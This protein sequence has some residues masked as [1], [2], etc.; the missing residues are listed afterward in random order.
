[1]K[2]TI[3]KGET[4]NFFKKRNHE[5]KKEIALPKTLTTQRGPLILFSN[6][7]GALEE[8]NPKVII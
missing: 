4:K 3:E 8:K 5:Q 2:D 7:K 6:T 1:M